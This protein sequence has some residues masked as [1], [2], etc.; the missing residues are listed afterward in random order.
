[1]KRSHL[2]LAIAG[3]FALVLVIAMAIFLSPSPPPIPSEAE[4][5][6]VFEKGGQ[7]ERGSG[8]TLDYGQALALY[9]KAA[10]SNYAP[11]EFA[12]GRMTE[13][14]RGVVRDEKAANEW[15]RRAA[16]HGMAEAQVLYAGNL[17]TG[18]GTADGKPDKIEALK[19]LMLGADEMPDPLS[20]Q[21]ARTTRDKLAEE[22]RRADV[23]AAEGR[24]N[25]WRNAHAE[26]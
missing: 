23:V 17:L 4:L 13:L 20:K 25:E 19:W 11:A 8:V 24:V 1:M 22:L 26:P 14:G 16:D 18:T 21:V 2:P 3:G 5:A 15:Y 12:L 6:A 10:E 7:Y 9:R